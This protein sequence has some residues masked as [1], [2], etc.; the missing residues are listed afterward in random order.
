MK[1]W[2]ADAVRTLKRRIAGACIVLKNTAPNQGEGER[3]RRGYAAYSTVNAPTGMQVL[4][5]LSVQVP[6]EEDIHLWFASNSGQKVYQN[7]YWDATGK[8]STNVLINESKTFTGAA[9]SV[10]VNQMVVTGSDALGLSS[11]ANYYKYWAV[12]DTTMSSYAQ[13]KTYTYSSA[14]G[15]T[16]TFT[17]VERIDGSGLGWTVFDTFTMYR[18]FHDNL[19]FAPTYNTDIANQIAAVVDN[20]EL[21]FSGGQSS[22][23]G[24]VGLISRYVSTTFFPGDSHTFTYTGTY[25]SEER[26]RAVS[27]WSAGNSGMQAPSGAEIALSDAKTYWVAIAPIYDGFQVGELS[28]I[29]TV[30]DYSNA[31]NANRNYIAS[32]ASFVLHAQ[33]NVTLARLNKRITDFVIYIAIDSGDTRTIG[34]QSQYQRVFVSPLTN[35]NPFSSWTFD[36]T[37][38]QFEITFNIDQTLVNGIVQPYVEDSGIVEIPTDTSYA[39]SQRVVVGEKEH[40]HIISN[41][42]ISSQAV[43]NRQ[44]LFT[45]PIG[46]IGGINAGV[47]AR[48]MFSNEQGFYRL[49]VQPTIGT[50]INDIKIVGL[51]ELLILKD[52]GI[53][54]ERIIVDDN[55][56]P[57]LMS[58]ILDHDAGC[59]TL[60]GAI[61]ADDGFIYF[62]GYEDIY[63]YAN[64][65]YERLIERED[66]QDWL[67]QY[68]EII[69]KSDKESISLT[70][71]PEGIVLFDINQTSGQQMALYTQFVPNGWRQFAPPLRFKWFAKLRNGTVLAVST[72]ATPAI[73][74]FSNPSTGAYYYSDAGTAIA[75][76]MDTGR[77][78]PSGSVTRDTVIDRFQIARYFDSPTQGTLDVTLYRDGI[79]QRVYTG[80]DKTSV[81]QRINSYSDDPHIGNDWRLDINNNA[82]PEIL[83]AGSDLRILS[84]HL[85]GHT[86]PGS[87]VSDAAYTTGVIIGVNPTNTVNGVAEVLLNR[88]QQTFT[89]DRAFTRTFTSPNEL[90]SVPAYVIKEAESPYVLNGDKTS[91]P[92]VV[93]HSRTLTQFV[94]SSS[95]DSVV[96]RF[97][98]NE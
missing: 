17:F 75:Y 57:E 48:S 81:Y 37:T 22:A 50:K 65:R 59:S 15:G 61:A 89:W 68:R 13:V 30:T 38:G 18:N 71:L 95:E 20:S 86:I 70:Y 53:I 78:V 46:G 44:D 87:R 28:R 63:R 76:R 9:G 31:N 82:S 47:I 16:S 97:E 58:S 54:L 34:R 24:N 98:A 85:F 25:I 72:E 64:Q 19:G 51:N 5:V 32:G 35:T 90:I 7:P 39:Y 62:A 8:L 11:T 83:N 6:S 66:Q 92:I 2:Y 96:F 23:V 55:G 40:R 45:N 52:R 26:L 29:E 80:V 69:P 41:V 27:V 4:K 21:F 84:I 77:F 56:I 36:N 1:F 49:T 43:V 3:L 88:A 12:K 73:Y 74:Q 93:I 94:A 91:V 79:A 60:Q 42:Y 33:I 14:A 67:Y 10:S